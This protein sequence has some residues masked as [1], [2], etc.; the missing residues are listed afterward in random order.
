MLLSNDE[1]SKLNTVCRLHRRRR[2]SLKFERNS[3][4]Y[5]IN[6]SGGWRQTPFPNYWPTGNP[7]SSKLAGDKPTLIFKR[8]F[9][10]TS[11]PAK[12]VIS[13]CKKIRNVQERGDILHFSWASTLRSVFRP[14]SP[15]TYRVRRWSGAFW[16]G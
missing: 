9:F 3:L 1:N 16:V 15:E 10:T 6:F 4:V 8:T 11:R 5:G 2:R 14:S 7:F 13:P 12:N